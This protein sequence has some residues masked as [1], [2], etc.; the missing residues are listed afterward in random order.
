MRHKRLVQVYLGCTYDTTFDIHRFVPGAEGGE[1]KIGNMF[2]VC[3]N[4][5][6]EVT[7]GFIEFEKVNACTLRIRGS[8]PNGKGAGSKPAAGNSHAGSNPVASVG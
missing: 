1:Y 6:A 4:H 7:R 3:P 2:A 8:D 5:H